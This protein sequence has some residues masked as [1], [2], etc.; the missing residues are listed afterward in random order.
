MFKRFG[1]NNEDEGI[2]EVTMVHVTPEK[3]LI[4]AEYD[5]EGVDEPVYVPMV[6]DATSVN[7]ITHVFNQNGVRYTVEPIDN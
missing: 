7:H 4:E 1:G 2:H 5:V 6:V 3:F